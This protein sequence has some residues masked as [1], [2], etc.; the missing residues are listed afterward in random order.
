MPGLTARE[1]SFLR[2]RAHPLEPLVAIGH[3][4]LTPAVLKEIERALTAHELIKVRVNDG[5]RASRRALLEEICAR[6]DASPGAAG[7]QSARALAA[8][9]PR[10]CLGHA[11]LKAKGQRLRQGAKRCTSA[12]QRS[13][14]A[15]PPDP[16]IQLLDADQND[17]R[18][19]APRTPGAR[20]G[21]ALIVG[22]A[23]RL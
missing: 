8:S 12:L 6:T 2:T 3:E 11:R 7:G 20:M 10:G 17:I 23:V 19:A 5:D 16:A 18:T 22:I 13:A 4:G 15:S 9:P 21:A 14:P 1:R